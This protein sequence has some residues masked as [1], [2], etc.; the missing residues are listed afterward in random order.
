MFFKSDSGVQGRIATKK[1]EKKSKKK[2]NLIH[3]HNTLCIAKELIKKRIHILKQQK[4]HTGGGRT[5]CSR[6][7]PM[8]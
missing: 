8:L 2:K 5:R 7:R 3:H 4:V 1:G 6:P